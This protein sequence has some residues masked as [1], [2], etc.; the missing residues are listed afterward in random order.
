MTAIIAKIGPQHFSDVVPFHIVA[1]TDWEGKTFNAPFPKNSSGVTVEA[2]DLFN[3]KTI[4]IWTH[5]DDRKYPNLKGQ[6]L[7]ARANIKTIKQN[8]DHL[9]V[10]LGSVK[11][12][13]SGLTRQ[14]LDDHAIE[15]SAISLLLN[16]TTSRSLFLETEESASFKESVE[17]LSQLYLRELNKRQN[18]QFEI[19]LH[20]SYYEKGF[21]NLNT[22]ASG[23]I[24]SK[25]GSIDL[26]LG[27]ARQKVAARLDRTSQTNGT[28]RIHGGRVLIDWLQNHFGL[29]DIVTVT[30]ESPSSLHLALPKSQKVSPPKTRH[31]IGSLPAD[32]ILTEPPNV[33]LTSFYGFAP[34]I[35]GFI[36]WT[37]AGQR[38]RFIQ[39]SKPGALMVVYGTK[40]GETHPDDQGKLLGIYECTHKTGQSSDFLDPV[41]KARLVREGRSE[42]WRDAIQCSRAWEIAAN[43]RP[44][45]DDFAHL[46]Y[47]KTKWREI[48]SQGIQLQRMEAEKLL[49]LTVTEVPIYKGAKILDAAPTTLKDAL[50][51]S[52]AGPNAKTDYTVSVEPDSPK[53][54]YI[55]K[56]AGDVANYLGDTQEDTEDKVIV[57]VGLSK[58]PQARLK[59]LNSSL[60]AGTYKWE[61]MRSTALDGDA[62]YSCHDVAIV[63]EDKMK[64]VLDE[65]GVSLGGEFF[66]ADIGMILRAWVTG[67]NSAFAAEL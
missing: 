6:G 66:L 56:L 51:P 43:E 34:E 50:R 60:P 45:I 55:F 38:E 59:Q 64:L 24:T 22:M 29:G 12:L 20:P 21:F 32:Q 52:Q 1:P 40:G 25:P 10:T 30:I 14:Y 33:W 5:V 67:K 31:L 36:G 53:E 26:F 47:D 35:W 9:S 7:C 18:Q 65:F 39:N 49:S 27:K 61:I 63:G 54:L 15:H 3:C 17:R 41:A 13:P 62:L 28:P 11:V 2:S 4:Y 46:S 42:R 37:K 57:K 19:T 44:F 58:S 48:G 8:S 16:H 23:L